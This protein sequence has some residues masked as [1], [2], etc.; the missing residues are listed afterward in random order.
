MPKINSKELFER[1]RKS[2][3][4]HGLLLDLE[5]LPEIARY[6]GYTE[7]NFYYKVERMN[8]DYWQLRDLF[9]RLHYTDSDQAELFK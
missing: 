2:I 1:F 3:L 4:I 7:R 8:F 9:K 6:L 5:G